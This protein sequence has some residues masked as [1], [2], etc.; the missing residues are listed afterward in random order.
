MASSKSVVDHVSD[1]MT[2]HPDRAQEVWRCLAS[3]TDPELDESVTELEFVTS[4]QV[5]NA[6][7]HIQFHLPTY[8]CAANFAYMMSADMQQAVQV[9]PWVNS[10]VV[11]LQEHMYSDTI[12]RGIA[13]SRSFQD[14]FGEEAS[15]E[16]DTVRATFRR[17]AFQQR[18]ELLLRFLLK[19]DHSR[20][21]LISMRMADLHALSPGDKEGQRLLGRYQEIRREWGGDSSA[22]KLA[23]V[24]V[25]GQPLT[26][27]RFEQYLSELRSI[28]INTQFNGEICRGLLDARY[29]DR[30][31]R[32]SEVRVN[33]PVLERKQTTYSD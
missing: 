33:F 7:V 9:L 8:W 15:D 25:D 21:A 18:Q 28:R 27:D 1:C 20:Q 3:V 16:L 32:V 19:N 23:F 26:I 13:A 5:H 24:S 12:N 4:V 11:E 31:G 14:T 10:V 2:E 22:E 6:D 30:E 29:G 17:K